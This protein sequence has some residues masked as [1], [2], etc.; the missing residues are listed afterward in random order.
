MNQIM[1]F[2]GFFDDKNNLAWWFYF[3]GIHYLSNI[4]NAKS[5]QQDIH[6]MLVYHIHLSFSFS[7]NKHSNKY[8]MCCSFCCFTFCH[9][10]CFIAEGLRHLHPS[11][12]ASQAPSIILLKS[13]LS[14]KWE[15]WLWW[16]QLMA[17]PGHTQSLRLSLFAMSS[18]TSYS[19]MTFHNVVYHFVWSE[20]QGHRRHTAVRP[21]ILQKEA[22]WAADANPPEKIYAFWMI[23]VCYHYLKR[24][25]RVLYSKDRKWYNSQGI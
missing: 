14:W 5:I 24:L 15:G 23:S 13:A 9:S 1:W 4:A 3:V 10:S 7:H 2:R 19:N 22:F 17:F 16:G 6:S 25:V 8:C 20:Q 21:V 12:L 18:H 11:P